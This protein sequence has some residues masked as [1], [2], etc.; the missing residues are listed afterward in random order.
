MG[1]FCVLMMG[2]LF[3][4]MLHALRRRVLTGGRMLFEKSRPPNNQSLT[5]VQ[6]A[7]IQKR[8]ARCYQGITV[9]L[10]AI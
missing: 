4:V 9:L 3:A 8:L 6:R 2:L 10:G 7:L 1:G 5:L